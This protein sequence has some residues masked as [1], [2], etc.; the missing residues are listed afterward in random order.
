MAIVDIDSTQDPLNLEGF[1]VLS[2]EK[3][4]Y[5]IIGFQLKNSYD[6]QRI[7]VKSKYNTKDIIHLLPT[8]KVTPTFFRGIKIYIREK[9]LPLIEQ[10]KKLN[11]ILTESID[12][13]VYKNLL[14]EYGLTCNEC[15]AFL[16]KGIYPVDGSCLADIS[17]IDIT[18]D[19]LYEN[20]FDTK[21]VPAFQSFCSFTIFILCDESLFSSQSHK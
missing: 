7:K 6:Q 12:V 1:S 10:L 2:A 4:P 15:Y 16:R 18:L 5:S 8:S 19:S 11:T 13:N 20:A 3:Y 17:N 21:S 14:E 9:Y